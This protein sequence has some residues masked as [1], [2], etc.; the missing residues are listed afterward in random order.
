MNDEL[1]ID[2]IAEENRQMAFGCMILFVG[3]IAW[4]IY[5]V[6]VIAGFWWL[7]R[8]LGIV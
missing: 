5:A 2:E 1:N 8:L 6:A 4:T 7:A 3:A